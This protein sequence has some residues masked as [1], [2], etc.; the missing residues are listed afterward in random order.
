MTG[1]ILNSPSSI[2]EEILSFYKSFMGYVASILPAVNMD[3]NEIEL[4]FELIGNEMMW[5]L[6]RF[7]GYDTKAMSKMRRQGVTEDVVIVQLNKSPEKAPTPEPTMHKNK[8]VDV[9]EEDVDISKEIP[10]LDSGSSSGSDSDEEH[11]VQSLFV[12]EAPTI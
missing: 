5:E 1:D 2:V 7:L 6:N 3:G 4:D 12:K 11:S 10:D 8:K 9:V